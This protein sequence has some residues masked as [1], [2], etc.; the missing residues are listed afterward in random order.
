MISPDRAY[1]E[2][3]LLRTLSS[4]RP[5]SPPLLVNFLWVREFREFVVVEAKAIA[6]RPRLPMEA[7]AA[8]RGPAIERK[9]A[10]KNIRR[11]S[12]VAL[13][14]LVIIEVKIPMR[15]LRALILGS[16]VGLCW[17]AL[18]TELELLLRIF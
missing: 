15:E 6:A 12:S 10:S 13:Q 11:V 1:L 17:M 7:E 9:T 4:R 18:A 5:D 3:K 16:V 14:C 2:A 8:R